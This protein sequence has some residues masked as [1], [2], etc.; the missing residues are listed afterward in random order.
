MVGGLGAIDGPLFRAAG[1]VLV[2]PND[3][4]VHRYGPV[5]VVVG[6]RCGQN[7]GEDPLPGTVNG[8]PDQVFVS[9]LE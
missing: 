2:G 9:G 3:G 5:D 4:G 8:P 7:G 6:V 1:G